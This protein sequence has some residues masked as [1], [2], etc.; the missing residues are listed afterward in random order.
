MD[1]HTF[2]LLEAR[3][4][5]AEDAWRSGN[6]QQAWECYRSIL[7]QR[8]EQ[9]GYNFAAL[10][11]ADLWIVERWA[12]ISIPFGRVHDADHLLTLAANGYRRIGSN[13]GFDLITLKRIHLC[14]GRHAP[15]EA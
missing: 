3:V 2:E 11:A 12:D 9:V 7:R 8:L 14:F 6:R 15:L 10:T 13:Y 1:R 5:E 4:Q